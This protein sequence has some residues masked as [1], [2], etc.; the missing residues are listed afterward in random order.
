VGPF[1]AFCAENG[2]F[3]RS[4]LPVVRP[5]AGDPGARRGGWRAR[6]AAV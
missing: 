5:T 1:R 4:G 2:G 3:R 6:P